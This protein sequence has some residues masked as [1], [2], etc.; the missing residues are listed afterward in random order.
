MRLS[1]VKLFVYTLF[2]GFLLVSCAGTKLT[3]TWV[4]KTHMGKPVSNILV[5]GLTFEGNEDVR[6]AFEDSFVEHLKAAGID[7]ESSMPYLPSPRDMELKKEEILKVV[8]K[9]N[10]DAVLITHLIGNDTKYRYAGSAPIWA[11]SSYSMYYGF[12]YSNMG[13]MRS[14]ETIHLST[15]LFDVKTEKLIWSGTSKTL[16][17]ESYRHMFDALVDEVI[18]KLQKDG[19]IPKK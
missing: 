13:Y 17:P 4:D 6:K 15:N 3:D 5:I 16:N 18:K 7:A 9:F 14:S 10:N 1:T 12:A 11:S 2:S 19:V 8:N